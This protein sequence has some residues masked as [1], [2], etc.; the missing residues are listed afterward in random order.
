MIFQV[1]STG[2][3]LSPLLY[4]DPLGSPPPAHMGG[5]PYSLDPSRGKLTIMSYC[6]EY[7]LSSIMRSNQVVKSILYL[8]FTN[9]SK[10]LFH[11]QNMSAIL[12]K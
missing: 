9:N 12:L 3:P 7:V 6:Y 8:I 11:N 1:R 4:G 5:L 10:N 2:S